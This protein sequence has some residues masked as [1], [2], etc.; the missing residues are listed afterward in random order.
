M[1]L[2]FDTDKNRFLFGKFRLFS[3][4]DKPPAGVYKPFVLGASWVFIKDTDWYFFNRDIG[5]AVWLGDEKLS[6]KKVPKGLLVQNIVEYGS[7]WSMRS[8]SLRNGCSIESIDPTYDLIDRTTDDIVAWATFMQHTERKRLREG[9]K[10]SW[11]HG[12]PQSGASHG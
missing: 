3:L 8:C 4:D 11:P 10:P 5:Q 6:F 7:E 1:I 12:T 2:G 9:K